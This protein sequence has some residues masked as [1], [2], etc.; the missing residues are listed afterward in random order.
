[1]FTVGWSGDNGDPDNFLW[2][3]FAS[4]AMPVGDTS[5]YKN[6]EVDKLLLE[7]RQISDHAKRVAIY[8][9]AQKLILDDA[10]WIFVNQTLQVRVTRKEVKGYELNP[11][12]M[13]FEMNKVSLQ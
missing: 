10:P 5:H 12:Q 1:M 13:F 3:L 11:T 6:P 4:P 9:K 7:G 2:S 8:E